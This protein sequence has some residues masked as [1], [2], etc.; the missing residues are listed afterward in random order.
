MPADLPFRKPGFA[1]I[2]RGL[3][4]DAA[5]GRGGRTALTDLNGGSVV[6]TLME[7]YAREMA[8]CYEQLEL[9]YRSAYLDTA[10]GAAL[11]NVVALI[12]L[13]RRPPGHLE[14]Q[15]TFSRSQ[16]APQDI[17]IP[18]GTL[19]AGRGQPVFATVAPAVLVQGERLVSVGVLSLEPAGEG[20][21]IV[22]AGLLNSMPRPIAGIEQVGNAA[23]LIPRQRA[24]TDE[25]LRQRARSQARSSNTGTLA[26][27]EQA[28]RSLGVREVR[29]LEYPA[30]GDLLPGQIQVVVGDAD[31]SP[32][33]L[34][35]I[36]DRIDQVRPAGI[37]VGSGPATRVWLQVTATLTLDAERP[38][39]ERKALLARLNG[40]L[41]AYFEQVA[42]GEPVHE[43]KIRS[44]LLG[45]DG[46]VGCDPSPGFSGL[47][48]PFVRIE[49]QLVGQASRYLLSNGDILVGPRE[50][51]GL[52][53]AE[54]PSRLTLLGPA[55]VVNVDIAIELVAGSNPA[56]VAERLQ[57][58][59]GRVVAAAAKAGRI[60]YAPLL[61]AIDLAAPP[62][63]RAALRVTV[64]H[65]SDGRAVDLSATQP[66][67]PLDA[68]EL[69]RLRNT[70][71]SVRSS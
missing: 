11:G 43:A 56:G 70:P 54:L 38:D 9:V 19:V 24:E 49:G 61:E 13:Q 5:S 22:K 37:Q 65:E 8:V 18:A 62:A 14:G 32:E 51:I 35:Q 36:A 15:V 55:P 68:R 7:V 67:E 10:E 71:V 45:P 53:P 42:V 34:E 48:E 63:T 23:D 52:L 21:A 25:E 33:L 31:V 20:G 64:L 30:D 29:V 27:L 47:L 6:R 57:A 26:A 28:V 41:A 17:H 69:P 2:A 58:G 39:T 1:E 59:P 12:G 16:G 60:D 3:L 46:V 66:G 4:D 50:R 40:E 44:I